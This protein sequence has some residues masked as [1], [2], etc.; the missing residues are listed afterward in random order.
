MIV[1]LSVALGLFAIELIGFLGGITMF[2]SF[3]SLLC[4]LSMIAT[5]IIY[6]SQGKLIHYEG[7]TTQ[8]KLFASLSKGVNSNCFLLEQTPS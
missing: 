6:Y 3:Q 8:S 4:I 2:T 1:G 5:C 7:E